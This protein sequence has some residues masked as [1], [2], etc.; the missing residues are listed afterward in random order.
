MSDKRIK[1]FTEFVSEALVKKPDSQLGSNEGGIHTDERGHSF[2]VKH[3]SDPDQAKVEALAGRIYHRMGI[4]T[5]SP[6]HKVVDGKPSVV[7]RWNP[8]L[9]KM[10]PEHFERLNSDQ[11]F[12]VGK[13]YHAAILTKNWDAVGLSHDNILHNAKTGNL[14]AVDTG[15]AFHF[16]ARGNRKDYGPDIEEHSS[17]RT[18]NPQASH[19]FNHVFRQHP[20]V[21][22]RSLQA[23]K[24]LDDGAI[25]QEFKNSGLSNWQ[26]LHSNFIERKR[27]L[28]AK[29]E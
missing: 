4:H 17:L 12:Q 13:M 25:H 10:K 16:R 6:E 21:E 20:D 1:T 22:K 24:S 28:L 7:S 9:A 23:V 27:K 3:Y 11:A 26:E 18:H 29:Y 5:V 2:Y 8:D 19:V 15:G 14:H